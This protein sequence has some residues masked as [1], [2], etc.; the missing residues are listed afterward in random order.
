M[1]ATPTSPKLLL[2]LV[3]SE[4]RLLCE[5]IRFGLLGKLRSMQAGEC[6]YQGM[7]TRQF[8]ASMDRLKIELETLTQKRDALLESM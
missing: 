1:A 8:D 7:S 3:E 6:N 4:M 5:T 2:R